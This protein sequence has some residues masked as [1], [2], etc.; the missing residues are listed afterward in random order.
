[1]LN[2][3]QYYHYPEGNESQLG[4]DEG[5][6][7]LFIFNPFSAISISSEVNWIFLYCDLLWC[8]AYA[9]CSIVFRQ[10]FCQEPL[11]YSRDEHT[12]N[13]PNLA[14]YWTTILQA[15]LSR[16]FLEGNIISNVHCYSYLR[17]LNCVNTLHVLLR[18]I[19]FYVI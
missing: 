4:I 6:F 13:H 3:P 1:M 8:R 15:S 14:S 7:V 19:V 10:S 5:R 9:V 2:V 16:I 12:R 17:I 11:C 18:I